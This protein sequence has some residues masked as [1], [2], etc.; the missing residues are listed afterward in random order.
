M[1]SNK[2]KLTPETLASQGQQPQQKDSTG[3]GIAV[4]AQDGIKPSR[5]L[6]SH[7]IFNQ[8]QGQGNVG[9]S[10]NNRRP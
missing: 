9:L 7:G 5:N 8:K 1:K 6:K 3:S 2:Q 10:N 4:C